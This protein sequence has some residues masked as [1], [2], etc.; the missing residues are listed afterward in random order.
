MEKAREEQTRQKVYKLLKIIVIIVA[1]L[2][3]GAALFFVF[4]IYINAKTA[5]REAKNTRMALQSADIEM[6]AKKKTVYNP[7]NPYNLEDGVEA[8]V[9]QIYK[10]DGKYKI[11]SYSYSMHEVTG[12]TYEKGN[13]VVTFEK[14]GDAVYWDVDYRLN[15]YHYDDDDIVVK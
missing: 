15:V 8:L 12:M 5:L 2:I 7:N 6:Y 14:K 1:A 3:I 13:Y 4:R 10:P 9:N 11:V